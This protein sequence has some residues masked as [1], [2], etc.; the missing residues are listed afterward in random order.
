MNQEILI[1]YAQLL[2]K[3]GVNLQHKQP[4]LINADIENASFVKLLTAEAYK[5]GAS[6]VNVNWVCSDIEREKL[7]HADESILKNQPHWQKEYYL[8]KLES[9]VAVISLVSANPHA[10]AGVPSERIAM[11]NKARGE[12]LKFWRQAVMNS[13]LTWCVAAVP[14]LIWA[15]ILKLE[16]SDSDKIKQLWNLIL[17]FSRLIDVDEKN[18]FEVHIDHLSERIKTLNNL[19]LKMLHYTDN[20]GTN[21][22]I[23]L[24]DGHIW[25]GGSEK[26]TKGLVFNANIP[27]EEVFTVPLRHG[28]NGTVHSS[29]P[30]VYQGN[31]ID[32]FTLTFENGKVVAFTA[33]KGEEVLQKL[34]TMDENSAYLGE[35]ALVDH[36]SPISLS[37][38][39]FYETLFDENASC[40][41]A[42]GAAYPICVKNGTKLSE[43]E[44]LDLGINQSITHVDFMIGHAEMNIMGFTKDGKKISIMNKGQLQI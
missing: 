40:H 23:E 32:E 16:G 18:S 22:D 5:L 20:N 21:L 7:L 6:D 38:R 26:S 8:H 1:K 36:Y 44:L 9:N 31:I 25:L 12:Q 3:K 35:V 4:L 28:V 11:K 27:T 14:S 34:I 24:P 29:K 39:I 41:L 43:K 37:N 30:L 19:N 42:F 33:K 15:D 10:L 13:E 2:L 17:H